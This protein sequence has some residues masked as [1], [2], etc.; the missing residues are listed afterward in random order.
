[1]IDNASED[2]VRFASTTTLYTVGC[3]TSN[4]TSCTCLQD[5]MGDNE[6]QNNDTYFLDAVIHI[7]LM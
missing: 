1:M 2:K 6:Y 5:D 4:I 7:I 3:S